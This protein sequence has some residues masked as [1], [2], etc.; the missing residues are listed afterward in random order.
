MT[1]FICTSFPF[2]SL[3]RNAETLK[4]TFNIYVLTPPLSSTGK[5]YLSHIR[6]TT[7]NNTDLLLKDPDAKQVIV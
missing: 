1:Y 6:A 5:D 2:H 3:Y 7:N 4:S